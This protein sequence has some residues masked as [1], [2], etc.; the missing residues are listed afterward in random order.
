MSKFVDYPDDRSFVIIA[1]L[2]GSRLVA[3]RVSLQERFRETLVQ[4]SARIREALKA[5]LAITAGDEF[6]GLFRDPLPMISVLRNVADALAPVSLRAGIGV[7]GL[8]LPVPEE[9]GA[10]SVFELDGSAFHRARSALEEARKR[11]SWLVVEGYEATQC[12]V[13][14]ALGELLGNL[15]DSWTEK[16]RRYVELARTALQKDVAYAC[17][18]SASVIS[19]SLKAAEFDSYVRS[20]DALPAGL[21][22]SPFPS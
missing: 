1:D 2:V 15:R 18:V 10:A 13:L 17:G 6:Q 21:R 16:Q 5:P 14:S 7:G 11:Q 20:E 12:R 3:D 9:W 8:S 22:N 19:E 4:E